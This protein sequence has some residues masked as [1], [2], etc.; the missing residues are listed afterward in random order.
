[1]MRLN[2]GPFDCTEDDPVYSESIRRLWGVVNPICPT[3]A[4]VP[5]GVHMLREIVKDDIWWLQL[6]GQ[7]S[8]FVVR[9]RYYYLIP[10]SDLQMGIQMPLLIAYSPAPIASSTLAPFLI[11]LVTKQHVVPQ[12]TLLVQGTRREGRSGR[13]AFLPI[14]PPTNPK[15]VPR[16]NLHFDLPPVRPM[17]LH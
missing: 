2:E 1:M 13:F 5:D 17:D 11:A 3:H 6:H 14:F 4:L 16:E 8:M 9:R 7:S 10:L 15:R 12:V